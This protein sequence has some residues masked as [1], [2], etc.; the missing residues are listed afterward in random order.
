[1]SDMNHADKLRKHRNVPATAFKEFLHAESSYI[2]HIFVEGH[3]DPSFYRNFFNDYV[4]KLGKPQF[5]NC[6]GKCQVYATRKKIKSRMDTEQSGATVAALYFVDKDL[7][8]YSC[9]EYA[10]SSEVFV[11]QHYSIENYLVCD[12]ILHVVWTD[13]INFHGDKKPEYGQFLKTFHH[14]LRRFYRLVQPVMVWGIH[15][16]RRGNSFK[17]DDIRMTDFFTFKINKGNLVL[18][19]KVS[20]EEGK[21]IAKLDE[22]SNTNTTDFDADKDEISSLLSEAEPKGFIRGKYET[23]FMCTFIKEYLRMLKQADYKF[24]YS[25][26]FLKN[27]DIVKSL[28]PRF[29][30]TPSEIANFLEMNLT[31]YIVAQ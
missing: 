16:K 14:E 31:S 20:S 12:E 6:G 24:K 29:S 1:M 5:Y 2:L 25:Q 27:D 21:M 11:T 15:H 18:A 3:T 28:G 8:D 4:S 19:Q 26:A 22:M 13:I 10:D 7:S 23:W 17:F 30:S 9:E